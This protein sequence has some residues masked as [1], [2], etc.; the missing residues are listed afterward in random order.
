MNALLQ[1]LPSFGYTVY[2]YADDTRHIVLVE[3]KLAALEKV[4]KTNYCSPESSSQSRGQGYLAMRAADDVFEN[5]IGHWPDDA[6]IALA[7]LKQHRTDICD[8]QLKCDGPLMVIKRLPLS[9]LELTD[10][11]AEHSTSH[12]FPHR[13]GLAVRIY[14]S[15]SQRQYKVAPYEAGTAEHDA[16]QAGREHR[17]RVIELLDSLQPGG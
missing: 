1:T 7:V 11:S 14:E 8:W 10:A 13:L 16:Y 9:A 17:N 3:C 4:Q 2:A 12:S 5:S 6:V 15:V